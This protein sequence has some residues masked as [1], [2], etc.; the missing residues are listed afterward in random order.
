MSSIPITQMYGRVGA[1]ADGDYIRIEDGHGPFATLSLPHDSEDPSWSPK[2]LPPIEVI[3]GQHRLWA[4]DH[5]AN[6]EDDD[7]E[8]PVVAF[9]GLDLTW[10]AYLF[11]TINIRPVRINTS[12]AFDLYPLLRTE[13]WLEHERGPRVY[14]ETRAQ[15]VVEA[16]Y[17]HP[18]ESLARS[19]QHAGRARTTNGEAVSLDS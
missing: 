6:F 2:E 13:K 5:T 12:L 19:Y 9:S 17:A 4:V 10:Q 1:V 7:Y 18:G 11:Y 15:E 8:L 3:D 14:R 16:L